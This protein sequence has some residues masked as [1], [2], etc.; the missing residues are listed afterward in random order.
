MKTLKLSRD[1]HFV[2]KLIDVIGPYLNPPDQ[3]LVLC[4]DETSRIQVLDRTR[5]GLL[6]KKGS[7]GMMMHD[8]VRPGT[9]IVFSALE[10]L[11][12]RVIRLCQQRH[13]H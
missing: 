3:V 10:L 6:L 9:T 8:Y 12:G 4:G 11:Q 1:P 5:L 2:K 7:C 13:R